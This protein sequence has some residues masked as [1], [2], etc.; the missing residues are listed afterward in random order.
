MLNWTAGD[1][2]AAKNEGREEI[3][4]GG[5]GTDVGGGGAM[6]MDVDGTRYEWRVGQ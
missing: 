1:R 3:V 6:R 5:G 4:T 2:A